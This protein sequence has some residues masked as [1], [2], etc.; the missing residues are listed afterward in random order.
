MAFSIFS[1]VVSIIIGIFASG[2]SSQ[3]KIVELYSVQK[4]GGYLMEVISRELR[5]AT[6]IGRVDD[7]S[8]NYSKDQQ[9][10][11]DYAIEFTNYQS[12]LVEYC[13]SDGADCSVDGVY[14]AK[15]I[16][17]RNSGAYLSKEIIS[18]PDI[19]IENLKFYTSESFEQT[20]PLITISMKVKSAGRYGT[21]LKLQ[22]SISLR[23]Y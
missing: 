11:N 1:V 4:D 5:M 15:N 6:N 7:V 12:D 13:R 20:Q 10:K 18:P 23:I 9:N 14:L 8:P 16:K 3:R 19:N 22:S 2:S 21:E 17:D